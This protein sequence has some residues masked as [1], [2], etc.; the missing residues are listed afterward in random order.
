MSNAAPLSGWGV[1]RV[2]RV[3]VYLF[4]LDPVPEQ[5]DAIAG[6]L[7]SLG[8]EY[9][10]GTT[11]P[12][13][14]SRY[15]SV[16][17]FCGVYPNYVPLPESD[18]T[19]LAGHLDARGNCYWEGGDVWAF[20]T[21]TTLHP[22]FHIRGLS[23]GTSDA[24]PIVGEPNSTLDG[25]SFSYGGENSFIDRLAP[26]VDAHVMLRNARPGNTYA[27]CI[28]YSGPTYRTIGSS[29]EVG[30][31]ED[32][33]Y[34]A[35]RV[36][37]VRTVLDWF[38][39]ESRADIYP[40]VVLHEPI[41]EW[42][43]AGSPIPITADI[44]DAS[45]IAEASVE[46]RVG[47]NPFQSAPLALDDGLFQ[48]WLPGGPSG[49]QITY[50]LRASDNAPLHN[51]ALTNPSDVA[52]ECRREI[53]LSVSF[54]HVTRARLR[55]NVEA[56][57]A[58]SWALTEYPEDV[59]VLEL[60]ASPGESI[61]FTT[62]VFDC[63]E[64]KDANLAFWHY[65]RDA[66]GHSG[67]LA[68]VTGS[69]DGGRSFPHDVWTV[70][71]RGSGIALEGN[72]S[73]PHLEWMIGESGV[74]L[75]FEFFGDWYWRL[76][77]IRLSGQTQPVT[78]PVKNLVIAVTATGIRLAWTTVPAA[79]RYEVRATESGS[80]NGP[81]GVVSETTDTTWVDS[82]LRYAARFYEVYA[83][84]QESVWPESVHDIEPQHPAEIRTPDIIW[85]LK[86]SSATRFNKP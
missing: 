68:R 44:Q 15:A 55:P 46:Y 38:G 12:A 79:I 33:L 47:E 1:E 27:V 25:C 53:P 77:D 3:P 31:L 18:A 63:S 82:D 5:V 56:G 65:L 51:E 19:R 70:E 6:A 80:I 36:H 17:I 72:V 64:L 35:T 8:V 10:R 60:H 28:A 24:G 42:S 76:R 52:I 71:A 67:V 29:V 54:S 49:S 13:D 59:P 39:I 26:E 21:S 73:I 2:G 40:P 66:Q 9:E 86:Q 62:D 30:C 81:Y 16:W 45:G 7:T 69:T 57:D 4:V 50:R 14:L 78:A 84:T 11:L 20:Q 32:S 34:P 23:D 74:A 41:T 37:L 83:V 48:G 85:N 22:Y 61:A 75:R 58:C 43:I